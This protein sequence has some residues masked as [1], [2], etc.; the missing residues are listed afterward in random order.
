M[1]DQPV[2][3]TPKANASQ[4]SFFDRGLHWPLG[5]VCLFLVSASFVLTT[6]ILGAGKGSKAVEP[7]YYA[8]SLDWDNEKERLQAADR[9]GWDIKLTASPT[10]DPLGTRTI[11][12]T[13]RDKEGNPINDSLVELVCFSQ[14]NAHEPL[15]IVLPFTAQ[16]QYQSPLKAMHTAGMWEFRISIRHAGEQALMVTS[17]ELE[18]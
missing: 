17:I 2:S 14:S 3:N 5:L 13:I 12:V 11:T 9:L 10:I 1:S 7:D 18:G 4:K 8:R 16:G 15:E 6:A